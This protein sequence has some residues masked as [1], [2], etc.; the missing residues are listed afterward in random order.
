MQQLTAAPRDSLTATQ[1]TDLLLSDALTV[2]AGAER[3]DS[4]LVVQED[5]SDDL[6]GG[7]VERVMNATVHGTVKLDISRVLAWGTDLIRPYMTLTSGTTTA[8]FNLGVF[9]LTT[10]ERPV[11]LTPET[12]SCAGYDR[13]YL[14][15]RPVGD[16]YTVTA[17]TD[18]LTAVQNVVAAAGL[19]GVYLDTTASGKTLPS[20]MVWPL[21]PLQGTA[22]STSWLN[23]IN[24]L[25]A[26]ISYR[27]MWADEN[28]YFRS[29]PYVNPA[30]RAP[31]FTFTTDSTTIVGID[32]TFTQDIWN[33]PNRWVFVQQ[34]LTAAPAEGAGQYTVNNV[35]T[36]LTSQNSRGY[37]WT[38]VIELAAADQ[39]SLQAQGDIIAAADQQVAAELKVTTGPFPV[40][41]HW[42]V[43]T[44]SD[45]A[46]SVTKVVCTQWQLDLSGADMN[47]IWRVVA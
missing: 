36:G 16:T 17:G 31:E 35:S 20:D 21:K 46:L 2:S 33:V 27:G 41:G 19:S 44:L 22:G 13:L 15:N 7:M 18:Y 8:R 14:L 45:P 39:A 34:N 30:A 29:E 3:L 4:N 37:V 6:L 38:K 11:G 12:Y 40:A 1:V 5:I 23:V 43:L 42:D 9:S 28:G 24:D 32:R 25:L 10:P 47:V 26:A